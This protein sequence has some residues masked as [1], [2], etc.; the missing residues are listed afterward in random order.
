M[1]VYILLKS[2]DFVSHDLDE[3]QVF[4]GCDDDAYAQ[5]PG[6]NHNGGDSQPQY[7]LE[8]VLRKWYHVDPSRELRCFVRGVRFIG[9]GVYSILIYTHANHSLSQKNSDHTT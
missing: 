7:S 9:K 4:R 1:D 3:E 2:S 5:T 6:Q 8:L